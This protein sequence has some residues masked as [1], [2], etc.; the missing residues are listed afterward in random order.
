[1]SEDERASLAP[2]VRPDGL[3]PQWRFLG[4]ARSGRGRVAVGA[5]LLPR[6]PASARVAWPVQLQL[7]ARVGVYDVPAG[8][9]SG[10][11]GT[12]IDI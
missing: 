8:I 1:M 4:C 6:P 5:S 10:A 11:P 7:G 2:E 3:W 9:A 12:L